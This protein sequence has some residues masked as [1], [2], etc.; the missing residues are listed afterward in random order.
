M[1]VLIFSIYIAELL[2]FPSLLAEGGITF[3]IWLG[4]LIDEMIDC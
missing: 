1:T 4:L 3:L 2:L